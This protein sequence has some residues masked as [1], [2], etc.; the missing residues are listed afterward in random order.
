MRA[1]ANNMRHPPRKKP[2]EWVFGKAHPLRRTRKGREKARA[3][4]TLQGHNAPVFR[5][6]N[7]AQQLPQ[8]G[9]LTVLLVPNQHLAHV[10]VASQQV[11]VAAPHQHVDWRGGC[12]LV[13]VFEQRRHQNNV[14]DEG[15]L[16]EQRGGR[17]NGRG[18]STKVRP[19]ERV[20]QSGTPGNPFGRLLRSG[21]PA[22]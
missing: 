12:G 5:S 1:V 13:Q 22:D 9:V 16:N 10:G 2:A 8:R 14:A 6:S 17:S 3:G 7:L 15:R 20:S 11:F 19:A 21:W 4:E 18:H